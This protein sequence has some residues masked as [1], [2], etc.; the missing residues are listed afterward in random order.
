MAKLEA[1]TDDILNLLRSAGL[2][3]F[4]EYEQLLTPVPA[5][6]F[7]TAAPRKLTCGEAIAFRGG[8]A[9]PVTLTLS[10]RMHMTVSA[11]GDACAEIM[12]QTVIPAITAAGY[13]IRS[14][15]FHAPEYQKTV[16]R[17]VSETVFVIGGLWMFLPDE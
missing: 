9:V 4:A 16:D 15:E 2:T 3:V 8:S 6:P 1:F 5:E 11:P 13:D 7:L 14:A 10:L 17:M 12:E